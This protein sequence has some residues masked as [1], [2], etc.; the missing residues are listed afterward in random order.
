MRPLFILPLLLLSPNA[1][2]EWLWHRD[3]VG[4]WSS[5]GALF[6]FRLAFADFPDGAMYTAVVDCRSG[7]YLPISLYR[8]NAETLVDEQWERIV[9]ESN[10]DFVSKHACSQEYETEAGDQWLA[11]SHKE[12]EAREP[13]QWNRLGELDR[14][15]L[16]LVSP[17]N[18]PHNE[19]WVVECKSAAVRRISQVERG[20]RDTLVNEMW[21]KPLPAIEKYACGTYRP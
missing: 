6:N 1:Q 3:D 8:D 12:L 4:V 11:P 19:V 20:D 7:R 21:F 10:A 13:Q 16:T 18:K 9:P 14:F 5:V 15:R 17:R 2:A